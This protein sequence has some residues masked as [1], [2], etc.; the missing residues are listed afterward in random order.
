MDLTEL[1]SE[2]DALDSQLLQL[3]LKR[4]DLINQVAD[5]KLQNKIPIFAPERE[6]EI[7]ER[8]S[9]KVGENKAGGVKLLYGIIMDLNKF[10]EYQR[11]P[12][13]IKVPTGLGG[14]SVRAILSDSPSALCRYLSPLAAAEVAISNIRSQLLPGGK[15]V[16]DLELIGE[17]ANPD[18]AAALSVLKD[19]AEQFTL[20]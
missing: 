13:E 7:L 16:V 14:A 9:K 10:R 3:I 11:A 5:Y 2:I 6:K 1:R 8:L 18:F 20:L 12:A 4:T 17:T 15:L 19:N